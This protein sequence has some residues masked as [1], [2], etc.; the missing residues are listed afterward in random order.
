MRRSRQGT[1]WTSPGDTGM[2]PTFA[3]CTAPR[4]SPAE[5]DKDPKNHDSGATDLG[6]GDLGLSMGRSEE[7]VLLLRFCRTPQLQTMCP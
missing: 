7:G 2:P 3:C 4:P 1:A 5:C 6:V